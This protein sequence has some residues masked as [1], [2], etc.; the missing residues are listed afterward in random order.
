MDPI[1]SP[2]VKILTGSIPKDTAMDLVIKVN[3]GDFATAASID[4]WLN[5]TLYSHTD[6]NGCRMK[7]RVRGNAFR[8]EHLWSTAAGMRDW[9][10]GDG[11]FHTTGTTNFDGE[12]GTAF[13]DAVGSEV[14]FNSDLRYWKGQEVLG[15]FEVTVSDELTLVSG[16]S[17][18]EY[19]FD[20]DF[21]GPR[22]GRLWVEYNAVSTVADPLDID[23][24]VMLIHDADDPITEVFTELEPAVSVW[25][26]LDGAGLFVPFEEGSYEFT[27]AIFKVILQRD[28]NDATRPLLEDFAVY[29]HNDGDQVTLQGQTTDAT[30]LTLTS[31]GEAASSTNIVALTDDNTLKFEGTVSARKSNNTEPAKYFVT[32]TISRGTG[33]ASVAM[34]TSNLIVEHET[35]DSWDVEM[36]ADTTNGGLNL[37]VTGEAGKTVDWVAD[38]YVREFG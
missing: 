16:A 1:Q 21:L 38:I 25:I 5:G 35:N 22:S 24:A 15:S 28:E 32:G 37:R 30:P 10:D 13:T 4:V 17:Y 12:A 36:L 8:P 3:Q 23:D 19:K 2:R 7:G 34:V 18:G 11:S 26:Q 31:D 33:A 20:F 27:T 14:T 9:I 29:F 6:P